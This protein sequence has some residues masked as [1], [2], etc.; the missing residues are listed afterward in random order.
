MRARN[1]LR[2][3]QFAHAELQE[4]ATLLCITISE[5]TIRSKPI[6]LVGTA[7]GSAHPTSKFGSYTTDV[8][9]YKRSVRARPGVCE[10][11]HLAA[12]VWHRQFHAANHRPPVIP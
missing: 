5:H 2:A 8:V 11:R 4:H 6:T 12:A 3:K 9:G 1:D 7:N 10:Y